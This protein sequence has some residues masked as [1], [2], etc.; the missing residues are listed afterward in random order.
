MLC[1]AINLPRATF[2]RWR[3]RTS[4]AEPRP[5][6]P[7]PAPPRA[8][9]P[10]ERQQVLDQLH[11]DRF[12]DKSP[13]E[14]CATLL[15]EGQYLCSPRTMYRIL[16]SAQEV[17]ERRDQLKHPVY[18]KP[19]LLATG[20][21]QVWS[22]DIT[23]LLGPEKWTYFYL[24]VIIDIF[25]RY[26][27][28]WMV[29]TRESAALASRL[30][31]ETCLKQGLPND[32]N[33][34]IHSDRGAPMKSKLLAQL[35]ADLGITKSF[36]RPQVSNDNPF[37]ESHFKTL[38]YHPGFPGRFGCIEDARGHCG[39]FFD[40]YNDEHRHS[41]I[42]ML[43]PAMLHYGRADEILA[44]RYNVLQAAYLAR[45]ERFVKG[46]PRVAQAPTAVWINPPGTVPAA[47]ESTVI[48]TAQV[49]QTY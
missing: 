25:S 49:S 32:H 33:L 44:A 16:A 4:G 21:N 27:V 45:P 41:G 2:Y 17:R 43:T 3:G 15:D 19:E 8:L 29:A 34:I 9:A 6:R 30:V 28:G 5:V 13:G 10:E 22:W 11:S 14:V 38:K 23:K 20:P 42:E 39:P 12:V 37:S 40:W 31:W 36:S 47:P 7:R 24:Y 46:E 48:T 35:L 26:V 1:S 18:T